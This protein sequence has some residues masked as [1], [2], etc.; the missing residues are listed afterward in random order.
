MKHNNFIE[1]KNEKAKRVF[2]CSI[3]DLKK[4]KKEKCTKNFFF[5]FFLSCPVKKIFMSPQYVMCI[6]NKLRVRWLSIIILRQIAE[7]WKFMKFVYDVFMLS[8]FC[9]SVN[10]LHFFWLLNAFMWSSSFPFGSLFQS[11]LSFVFWIHFSFKFHLKYWICEK[12]D[13]M[14]G[15]LEAYSV[16]Q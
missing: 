6:E 3:A 2:L 8:F 11:V 9:L 1:N 15:I 13:L 12:S 14:A 16:D 7:S 4:Y 10:L 5:C